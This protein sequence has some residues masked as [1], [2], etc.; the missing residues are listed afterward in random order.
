[1][2]LVIPIIRKS[3]F[4]WVLSS[5]ASSNGGNHKL[6]ARTWRRA[7]GHIIT[8]IGG[9]RAT[10]WAIEVRDFRYALQ[11][12]GYWSFFWHAFIQI[13]TKEARKRKPF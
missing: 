13:E 5:A 6:T 2:V 1:M 8:W 12:F 3:G 11:Q 9:P 10:H 4:Q 7:I